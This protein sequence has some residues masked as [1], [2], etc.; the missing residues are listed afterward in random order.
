MFG[1]DPKDVGTRFDAPAT[2][3]QLTQGQ[4]AVEDAPTLFSLLKGILLQLI[5]MNDDAGG[6]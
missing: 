4:P 5:I 3:E 6:E 1:L 2:Q